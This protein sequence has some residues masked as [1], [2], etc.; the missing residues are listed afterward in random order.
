MTQVPPTTHPLEYLGDFFGL[1]GFAISPPFVQNSSQRRQKN[2]WIAS[3]LKNLS[4]K[5]DFK[6]N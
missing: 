5:Y 4:T 1:L 3:L 2:Q 6:M